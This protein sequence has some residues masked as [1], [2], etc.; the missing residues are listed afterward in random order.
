MALNG[1]LNTA[2]DTSIT[3]GERTYLRNALKWRGVFANT[4]SYDYGDTVQGSDNNG[5][6]CL[7]PCSGSAYN[8]VGG[9]SSSGYWK[10]LSSNGASGGNYLGAWSS[11]VSYGSGDVVI[12]S[13]NACYIGVTNSTNQNPV[14]NV[15]SGAVGSYWARMSAAN[16]VT[17]YSGSVQ[18]GVGD[19]VFANSL[20]GVSTI[21]QCISPAL[22][23]APNTNPSSWTQVTDNATTALNWLGVWDSAKTY[24]LNEVVT[25]LG[26]AWVSQN[27]TNLNNAPSYTSFTY[28]TPFAGSPSIVQLHTKTANG[29]GSFQIPTVYTV[30][31]YVTVLTLPTAGAS[32]AVLNGTLTLN[33][34]LGA[35]STSS[36]NTVTF[37]VSD[38][39]NAV[40]SGASL[41][42]EP[43]VGF[44]I[45]IAATSPVTPIDL[46]IP[47]RFSS[48]PANIYLVFVSAGVT[49]G[50][51]SAQQTYTYTNAITPAQ[52]ITDP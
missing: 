12:G 47:Y 46:T 5:Y 21:W 38:T 44:P 49:T 39:T 18:Y 16:V 51:N 34:L 13:N 1:I 22:G 33:G 23:L 35:S 14:T 42:N 7:L 27:A 37:Y 9:V 8:P 20:S 48:T 36:G 43:Y 4:V 45:S 25:S 31:S 50:G 10:G 2:G 15:T 24:G 6:V 28:W 52:L 26:V 41:L 32:S 30:S 40:P 11:S 29:A 19:Q 17:T 3:P